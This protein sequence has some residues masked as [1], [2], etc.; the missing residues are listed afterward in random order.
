[1]AI[2]ADCRGVRQYNGRGMTCKLQRFDVREITMEFRDNCRV[3]EDCRGNCRGRPR[4]AVVFRGNC[5]GLTSVEI[6]VAI[7]GD[8]RGMPWFSVE[9]AVD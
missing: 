5:S 4:N 3:L 6:A 8:G 1:M 7:D 2:T 9:I